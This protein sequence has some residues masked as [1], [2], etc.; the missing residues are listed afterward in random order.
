VLFLA[1]LATIALTAQA[2][3]ASR[4]QRRAEEDAVR[5]YARF[6][7]NNYAMNTQRALRQT[8]L[9]VFSWLGAKSSRLE[10]D[11]LFDLSVL[12]SA[13][14]DVKKCD[15]MWDPQPL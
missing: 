4:A 5:D 7:A 14:A 6:A 10:A 12:E 2:W 11:S 9:A 1:L 8:A 3:L 15:C 13:E